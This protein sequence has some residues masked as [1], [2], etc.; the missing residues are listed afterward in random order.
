[1][2][3]S[4]QKIDGKLLLASGSDDQ[5]VILWDVSSDP[6]KA[7]VFLRLEGFDNPIINTYFDSTRLITVDKSGQTIAWEIDPSQWIELA[8]DSIKSHVAMDG[9]TWQAFLSY[10]A[11]QSPTETCIQ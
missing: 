1:L 9:E 11:G 7:G 8:C 6:S 2:S 3:F 10:F 4:P 5:T